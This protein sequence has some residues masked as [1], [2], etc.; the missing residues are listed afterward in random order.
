M[1]M[2]SNI[3]NRNIRAGDLLELFFVA[4]ISS[5]LFTRFYLH[6][7][8]YP[9]LGGA[10]LHIA[11]M[12]PGG[13][14]MLASIII[15]FAFLGHR[16]QRLASIVG[17][18]GF[19]LFIDELGK[20]ITRDNNYFFQPTIALMY[21]VFIFLF[22]S[23]RSLGRQRVLTQK[24]YLLNALALMEEAVIHDL[25]TAERVRV[26]NYLHLADHNNP[27]VRGLI[28]VI[29][30]VDATKSPDRA[31]IR[32]LRDLAE[33]RYRQIITS[34]G[35]IRLVDTIFVV[36]ALLSILTVFDNIGDAITMAVERHRILPTTGWL[37]LVSSFVA[38]YFIICGVSLMRKARLKAYQL[39]MKAMLVNIFITQFF[40]FYRYEFR[41]L[42]QFALYIVLYVMLRL[43]I[44]EEHRIALRERP[45]PVPPHQVAAPI[46]S[47]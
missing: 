46:A 16:A 17:G 28:Q 47:T 39:F 36:L 37:Q 40:A 21:L 1:L 18:I 33:R 7:T 20:F 3:I 2:L 25:D 29:T 11:H 22:M 9:S 30:E 41:A 15:M 44:S 31:W 4:A 14:L 5:V 26:I 42:P 24:E 43:G 34:R 38:A 35:G 45:T 32:R 23:F 6:L 10:R 19:G 8:N 12:L 13:L 27:L